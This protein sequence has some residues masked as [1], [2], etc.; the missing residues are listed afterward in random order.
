MWRDIAATYRDS[1]KKRDI[2][3]FTEWVCRPPAAAL[4]HVL[5]E[6]RITPN[7]VT[8][9]SFALAAGS[10]TMVVLLPGYLW[11]IAAIVVFELSF[12]LD[13]ADGQLARVR[14]ATSPL[15]HL[16]DFLMDELKAMLI[17]A[18]VAARLWRESGDDLY[19]LAGL[20]GLFCIAAALSLTSFTR[21]PEYGAE[22][23]GAEGQPAVIESGRSLAGRGLAAGMHAARFVVHYPQYIWLTAAV[24]RMDLY[25][26]AYAGVHALYLA[27]SLLAVARRLGRFERS[28]P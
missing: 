6:T 21:R 19:L 23:P 13:C 7:Q 8:F 4:V 10:A 27:R 14:Q 9:A 11:L 26:W 17:F 24:N 20:G 22:P 3:R 25:F 2:N 16:L 18:S 15:G 5:R 1:K 12:V 28:A